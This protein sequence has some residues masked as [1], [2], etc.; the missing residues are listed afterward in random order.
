M[1]VRMKSG[2]TT[3]IP[4]QE[5]Q[6]LTFSDTTTVGV[7]RMAAAIKAFTL[8]LSYPDPFNPNP[9]IEYELP[10]AGDVEIKIFSFN[11]Q[12]VKTLARDQQIH[13][14]HNVVWDGRNMVG[15]TKDKL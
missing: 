13:G 14:T 2:T 7:E 5:I 8:L 3:T 11:G 10:K 12:L 6:K 9:T 4:V 15:I 1:N